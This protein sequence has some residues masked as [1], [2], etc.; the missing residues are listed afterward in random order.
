[1]E[2]FLDKPTNLCL[3]ALLEMKTTA[4]VTLRFYIP[5]KMSIS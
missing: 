4:K 3:V 1:M 5:L 2:S